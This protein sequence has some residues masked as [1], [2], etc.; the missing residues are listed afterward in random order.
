MVSSLTRSCGIQWRQVIEQNLVACF[1]GGLEVNGFDLDER[2]I[3]FAFVGRAHLSADGVAGL[4]VKFADLGRGD[5]DIVWPGKV[6]VV[7]RAK[8]AVAVG[9][10][11]ED[12]FGKDVA[13]FFALRLQD[14]EDEVLL[15]HTAGTGQIQGPC[16]L[17]QLGDVLFFQ[18]SNG[19]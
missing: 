18:F 19:H 2:E 8:E 13:F 7:G 9:Q 5:V 11:F 3:F 16:D 14:F 10:D 4:E 15:A 17:G 1:V 6:I 12:A